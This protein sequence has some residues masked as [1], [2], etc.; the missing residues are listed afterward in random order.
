MK[1]IRT[2]LCAA[3]LTLLACATLAQPTKPAPDDSLYRAWGGKA[4]IRAVVEDFVPRLY[5]HPRIG[6]FFKNTNRKHLTDMLTDQLCEQSGG[7][8]KYEGATMKDAHADLG[9]GKGDFNA[10]V[11]A[12]QLSMDAKG[13]P[14]R[15]QNAMLAR[16]APMHREI[17]A[18]PE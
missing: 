8:C 2:T 3:W 14:F 6:H 12:L 16:L 5:A 1:T 11:E 9:I 17:V 18:A 4:G 7:P 10:L 15:G 13:I